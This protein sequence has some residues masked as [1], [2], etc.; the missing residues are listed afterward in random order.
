MRA[1]RLAIVIVVALV[2][3]VPARGLTLVRDGKAAAPIVC[4]SG[5]TAA[6]RMAADEVAQYLQRISGAEFRVHS[7]DRPPAKG[8]RVL[9]GPTA[10]AQNQGL[11]V[12]E[13]GPEEWVIRTVGNDLVIVGGRPRG[14]IYAAYHFLED[15]LGVHWWNPFEESV[16]RRKTVHLGQ[17][18]LRG[19]PALPYRDIYMLYGRDG[20][21][22][23]ARNRLNRDGD[24]PITASYGG[25][26]DYGPPYHV[27][28]F[29]PYF[30][31]QQFF[32][33]HPEWYSLVG[34]D[35]SSGGLASEA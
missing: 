24:A 34:A 23:A 15:V 19:K 28:T 17:L 9:V 12:D 4:A 5:A 18:N 10:V 2:L 16:P 21:R 33:Q 8:S 3:V 30:P 22:F 20:G 26:R 14:T 27:H 31:P 11:A 6:E 29:S 7:E 25:G 35:R 32:S 13:L 1:L